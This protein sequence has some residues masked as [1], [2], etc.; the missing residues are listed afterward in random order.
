MTNFK[1]LNLAVVALGILTGGAAY[2][3]TNDAGVWLGHLLESKSLSCLMSKGGDEFN[4]YVQNNQI[5]VNAT[6]KSRREKYDVDHTS[7]FNGQ[8]KISLS[9]DIDGPLAQDL[10]ILDANAVLD[11]T[12]GDYQF[13]RGIDV[14]SEG[15]DGTTQRFNVACRLG[16]RQ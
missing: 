11:L 14:Y 2:S 1:Y 10:F 13:I 12:K 9:T 3:S 4:F 5:D 15:Y 16:V 8:L 6:G 7:I